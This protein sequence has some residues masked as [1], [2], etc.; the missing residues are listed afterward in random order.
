MYYITY[1]IVLYYA[2]H[3]MLHYICE[4]LVHLSI[5]ILFHYAITTKKELY[6]FKSLNVKQPRKRLD[7]QMREKGRSKNSKLKE[8]SQI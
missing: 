5:F 7:Y 4:L 2:S 6:K 1:N 3:G 8:R